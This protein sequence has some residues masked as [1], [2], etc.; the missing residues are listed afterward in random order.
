MRITRGEAAAFERVVFS[1]VGEIVVMVKDVPLSFVKEKS[2]FPQ[3]RF[4]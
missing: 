2:P 3:R 4:R 1:P